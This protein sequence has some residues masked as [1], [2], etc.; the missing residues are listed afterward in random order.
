MNRLLPSRRVNRQMKL[1][2]RLLRRMGVNLPSDIVE[3]G[4]ED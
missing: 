4:P 2:L 3:G 1:G